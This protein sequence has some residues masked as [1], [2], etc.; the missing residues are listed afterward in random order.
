MP[1]ILKDVWT[2]QAVSHLARSVKEHERRE[3]IKIG[4]TA[5][6]ADCLA[7]QYFRDV[8]VIDQPKSILSHRGKE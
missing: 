8:R 2:V 5:S 1:Q 6:P 4:F 7:F 3:G